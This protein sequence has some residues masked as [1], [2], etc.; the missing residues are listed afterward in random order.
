MA[1]P[2]PSSDILFP[3]SRFYL[4]EGLSLPPVRQVPSEQIPQPYRGMLDHDRDMTPTLELFFR[5]TIAISIIHSGRD[6]NSYTREVVLYTEQTRRPVRVLEIGART[7]IVA[8]AL[9]RKIGGLPVALTYLATDPD[10]D[11]AAQLAAVKELHAGATARPW[12]PR[13]DGAV[14]QLGGGRSEEH[15]SDIQA[16]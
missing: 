15:T 4:Q 13:Q 9:L 16:R 11:L 10:A 8:G 3:L 14:A 7:G 12:D 5:E 2:I 1:P 6:G